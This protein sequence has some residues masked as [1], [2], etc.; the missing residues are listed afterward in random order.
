MEAIGQDVASQL[1]SLTASNESIQQVTQGSQSQLTKLQSDIVSMRNTFLA[2]QNTNDSQ[3]LHK[4]I[5]AVHTDILSNNRQGRDSIITA[6]HHDSL[7]TRAEL[8]SLRDDL[9]K[10]VTGNAS[11]AAVNRTIASRL[12]GRSNAD[13]ATQVGK[14]LINNPSSLKDACEKTILAKE[15]IESNFDQR[16]RLKKNKSICTCVRN[17]L[18]RRIGP[19]GI[20]DDFRAPH[21]AKCPY[22]QSA[23]ESWSYSLSVRLLP[24]VQRT[25]E[26]TFAVNFG[27][28]G[29][30]IGTSL[31]YFG[32]VER[33]KSPAFQLFDGFPD[34]CASRVDGPLEG[35]FFHFGRGNRFCFDWDLKLLEAEIP[36][37]CRKLSHL[38]STG[39]SPAS[40]SDEYGNTLLHVSIHNI[41]SYRFTPLT[42]DLKAIFA[43]IGH[44]GSNFHHFRDQ[45]HNLAKLVIDAGVQVDAA[46]REWAHHGESDFMM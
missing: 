4:S 5:D 12:I 31:R 13:L 32:T 34:R 37:L 30:S 1:D 44:L 2:D 26:I 19:F 38:L 16:C 17:R 35:Q 25:V 7:Q 21:A 11:Y 20:A 8:S 22:H 10:I 45:L 18:V 33:W 36:E 24:I 28:G 15:A 14:Q 3:Q 6:I 39:R 41:V 46:S 42:L 40:Y 27:A 43:L 29:G 9:L 23:W